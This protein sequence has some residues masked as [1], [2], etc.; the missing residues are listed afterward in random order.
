MEGDR[1]HDIDAKEQPPQLHRA[2]GRARSSAMRCYRSRR[3]ASRWSEVGPCLQ[4]TTV[5]WVQLTACGADEAQMASEGSCFV[6][7]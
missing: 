6:V 1:L 4:I 7:A 2:W 3:H 5:F